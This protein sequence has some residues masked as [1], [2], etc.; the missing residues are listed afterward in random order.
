M[1]DENPFSPPEQDAPPP[2][3]GSGT[4]AELQRWPRIF[5]LIS[6]IFAATAIFL[7]PLVLWLSKASPQSKRFESL[8]PAWYETFTNYSMVLGMAFGA[9]LLVAG[10]KLRRQ[11]KTGRTL[12]RFYAVGNL[13]LA[14]VGAGANCNAFGAIDTAS[15]AMAERAGVVGG[16][17][18]G[19]FGAVAGAAYPIF[20]LIWFNRQKIREDV[21]MWVED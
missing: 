5:G 14:I 17:I 20:L 19:L 6:I 7:S 4:P 3:T 21:E 1:N 10:L 18:G 11:Q 12:H 9:M 16:M 8:L 13:L 15:L 2:P